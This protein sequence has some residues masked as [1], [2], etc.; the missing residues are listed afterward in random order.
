MNPSAAYEI[1]E[2]ARRLANV[3]RPAT[4]AEVDHAAARLRAKYDED[5]A[6]ED[7]LTGWLPWLAARAGG[8]RTW[9]APEVGEQL[10]LLS[11]SGELP[12]AVALPAIYRDDFPAPSDSPDKR[13]ERHADGATIEY[14]RHAHELLFAAHDGATVRLGPGYCEVRRGTQYLELTDERLDADVE[15]IDITA[16]GDMQLRARGAVWIEGDVT[17]DGDL[18]V[19][20]SLGADGGS[21][22]HRGANVG[23]DHIHGAVQRGADT[24][25]GPS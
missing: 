3:V 11:P 22:E 7:V 6:G 2:L 18:T 1:A 12:Q 14:D 19:A 23:S 20:G 9:W 8:D 17:I 21:F 4:V 13:V 24:S 25:G 15:A 5:A 16:R 10:L